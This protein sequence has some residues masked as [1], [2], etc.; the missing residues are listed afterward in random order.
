[1]PLVFAITLGYPCNGGSTDCASSEYA[2]MM[3]TFFPYPMIAGGL[4][5]GYGMKKI[6]D[7]SEE[8]DAGQQFDENKKAS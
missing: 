1:M 2:R 7:S 8:A 6:A 3:N 4:L 5:I